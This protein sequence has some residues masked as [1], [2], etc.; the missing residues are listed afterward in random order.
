MNALKDFIN[1]N[2][3]LLHN[4]FYAKC[5]LCGWGVFDEYGH[6]FHEQLYNIHFKDGVGV[7]DGLRLIR[8][9][10]MKYAY[11][12]NG[13]GK[14][15]YKIT[16]YSSKEVRY[17]GTPIR[18]AIEKYK[19]NTKIIKEYV[20]TNKKIMRKYRKQKCMSHGKKFN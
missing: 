17:F 18:N 2:P 13:G 15:C 16:D 9:I 8:L 4:D 5:R 14:V 12:E 10:N 3:S 19:A 7:Y 1:E 6:Q 11:I 20:E